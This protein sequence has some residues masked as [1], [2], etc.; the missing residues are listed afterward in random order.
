MNF[1][2]AIEKIKEDCKVRRNG[3]TFG[4]FYLDYIDYPTGRNW[5]LLY[6]ETKD[7]IL[8][9]FEVLEANDLVAEDWE[10]VK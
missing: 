8:Q 9:G 4:Y 6:F 3:D 1:G 7:K 5:Y 10:I 2:E